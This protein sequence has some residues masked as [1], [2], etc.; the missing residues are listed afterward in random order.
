MKGFKYWKYWNERWCRVF[1]RYI[2]NNY[3]FLLCVYLICLFYY[4]L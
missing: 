3:C 1:K 4:I 2:Y